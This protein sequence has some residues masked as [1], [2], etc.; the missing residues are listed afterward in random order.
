VFLWLIGDPQAYESSKQILKLAGLSLV[1]RS[2][3]TTKGQPH[4]SKRGKP[5][6]RKQLFMLALRA[7]RSDG[8]FRDRFV[9]HVARTGGKKLPVVVAVA[10]EMLCL[11]FNIARERRCYTVEPPKRQ[12][13]RTEVA[14]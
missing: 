14:A 10:R 9:R 1:E 12:N 13:R 2:S 11:M 7:V 4:I 6:L 5:L 8:M 3:G